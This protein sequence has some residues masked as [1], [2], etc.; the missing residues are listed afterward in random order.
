MEFEFTPEKQRLRAPSLRSLETRAKI[1]D[2]AERLFAERGFDG[3]SMRDIAAEAEVRVGLVSH[4]AG[5]KAALFHVVVAR[6]ADTLAQRRIE[7]LE[8]RKVQGPVDLRAVLDCF[9]TPYLELARDGGP[10]WMAY[11]RLVA[12]VSADARWRSLA[13]VCFDPTAQRFVDEIAS[14]YPRA[15]KRRIAAGFVYSVA[16]LLAQITSGWRVEALGGEGPRMRVAD[17]RVLLDFCV[18]GIEASMG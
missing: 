1:L 3:T 8:A 5:N 4:H 18:A 7:A 13:M 9:L 14:L 15:S 2:A 6:R 10:Q 11:A 17:D 12:Y 16:G